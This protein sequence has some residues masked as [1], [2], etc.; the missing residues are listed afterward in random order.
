MPNKKVYISLTQDMI[1]RLDALSSSLGVSRSAYLA[2][3]IGQSVYSAEKAY[4]AIPAVF[5]QI[6]NDGKDSEKK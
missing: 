4:G 6:A 3:I 2:L 1:K 5:S